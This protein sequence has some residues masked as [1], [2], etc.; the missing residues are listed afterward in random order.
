MDLKLSN[1]VAI[2]TGASRG[3]GKSIA[4]NLILQGVKVAIISRSLEDLNKIKDNLN[5]E[6]IICFE[7]NITDYNQFKSVVNQIYEK[8]NKI[9]ILI[10]N[11]GITRDKILL[12]LSEADWD[13]VINVNL[14]GYYIASKLVAKYMLK[15][16]LGKIINISSVIGQIGNS[17]QSNYAAS[18][19]GVEGMTRSLAVELG[20][21]NININCI[22]PGYIKTDMTKNLNDNIINNMK[23]NIPLNKLGTSQNIADLVSFLCSDL[24][25]Y[26]TGQVIN[27]DGGMTIK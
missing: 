25:S 14:K 12:R 7:C 27:V 13:D 5:S 15:N 21:R 11:A 24:S 23:Q 26:I 1:K 17:G 6:N 22:A 2:V 19:A 9:D 18:K 4:E 20:S 3:I 16:K 8:W 10:N